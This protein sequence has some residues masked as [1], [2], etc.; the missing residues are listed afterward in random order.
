MKS[1]KLSKAAAHG[2]G[3]RLVLLKNISKNV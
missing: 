1:E 2:I 3:S